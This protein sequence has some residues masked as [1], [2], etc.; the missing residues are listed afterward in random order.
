MQQI[1][2]QTFSANFQGSITLRAKLQASEHNKCTNFPY[3]EFMQVY[4]K[5][6]SQLGKNLR[7]A[8]TFSQKLVNGL[9]LEI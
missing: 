2:K 3:E 6:Y 4:F 8:I 1:T 5:K 9:Q 7:L